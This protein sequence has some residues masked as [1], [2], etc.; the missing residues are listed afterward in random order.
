MHRLQ[1]RPLEY[2]PIRRGARTTVHFVGGN[3]DQRENMINFRRHHAPYST[4]NN[5]HPM[6]KSDAEQKIEMGSVSTQAIKILRIVL[7]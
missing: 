3:V 6:V 4:P 5:K 1:T 7:D 2:D